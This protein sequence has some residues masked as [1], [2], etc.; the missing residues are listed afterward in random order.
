MLRLGIPKG[1]LQDS[2]IQLMAKAGYNFYVNGRSYILSCDDEEIEGVLIRA[3]EI[4]RYV[5]DGVLDAG[6]T[7]KDWILETESEVTEVCELVYSKASFRP[8]RWV[9]AVP[10][11]SEIKSVQ[12]LQNKR[13]ATE[14]VNLT[15]R[16]LA[17]NNVTAEVEFSWG[18][19]EIKAPRLVDAIVEVTETGSSLKANNLRIVETILVS[20]PRLIANN[21]AFRKPPIKNQLENMTLLLKG[22]INSSGKVGLKFNLERKNLGRVRKVLPAMKNPTVSQL[23]DNAWVALETIIDEAVVRKIIPTLKEAGACDIIEY[24]LNKVIY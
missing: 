9:L 10:E 24:P 15:R 8:V 22:A 19:T 12:D 18:A 11:N 16:Y 21:Q 20:T 14:A 4:A 1:S 2:T 3:Q 13:I 23:L 6:I 5:E 17:E 7:G